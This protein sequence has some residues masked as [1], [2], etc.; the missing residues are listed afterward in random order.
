M[1]L[2]GGYLEELHEINH[3]FGMVY[4][5]RFISAGAGY[6]FEHP[7]KGN[8]QLWS[9]GLAG[10]FRIGRS[11][12]TRV[13]ANVSYVKPLLKMHN[14]FGRMIRFGLNIFLVNKGD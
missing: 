3:S 4:C 9:F 14:P 8:S 7:T 12:T 2:R 5:Y 10:N 13:Q 11:G 6:H 1:M